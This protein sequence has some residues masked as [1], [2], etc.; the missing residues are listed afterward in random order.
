MLCSILSEKRMAELE[1]LI[2]QKQQLLDN[3]A[4]GLK[5]IE[6]LEEKTSD[7]E[8]LDEKKMT[9][10]RAK[11]EKTAEITA[12]KEELGRLQSIVER[13]TNATVKV[14]ELTYPNVEVCIN[15]SKLVTKD[16]VGSAEFVEKDEGIVM[17]SL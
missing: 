10:T 1:R 12:N 2:I 8:K 5:Q 7:R 14:T 16:E 11:I 15:N 3:I 9:L 4:A 6:M 17:M 13:S